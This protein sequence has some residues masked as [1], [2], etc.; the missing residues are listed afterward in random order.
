M[1]LALGKVLP[2]WA[3]WFLSLLGGRPVEQHVS[4]QVPCNRPSA[5][6]R[7]GTGGVMGTREHPDGMGSIRTGSGLYRTA[8]QSLYPGHG[9]S[10]TSRGP[11]L[12]SLTLALHLACP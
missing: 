10:L 2:S 9:P 7:V 8:V 11:W 6:L 4:L 12:C 3:F 5:H 1:G